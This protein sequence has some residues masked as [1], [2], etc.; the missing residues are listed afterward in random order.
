MRSL[1]LAGLLG[2]ISLPLSGQ[3]PPTPPAAGPL[4]PAR[5]P[6]FQETVLP[7]G[8]RLVLVEDHRQAVLSL[9]LSLPA[10]TAYDPSGNEGLS[11]MVAGLL[12]K[13]AGERSAEDLAATIEGVGGSL[14]AS[15]EEDFLAIQA[16]VLTPDAEL[17]FDLL[18]D[19][20]LR[21]TF[22][23]AEL[24]L[25]RTQTLSA[26]R[27]EL[28]QPA[29]VASRWLAR[30]LYGDRH[31]YG[32]SPTPAS[33]QAITRDDVTAFREA[34]F[35]PAGALLVL[36]GD[37][38]LP[39]AKHLAVKAF[40]EW[41]GRPAPVPPTGAP[42]TRLKTEILLVHRAGSVQSNILVGNTTFAPT[43]TS[44]YAATVA[45]K[46]LGGG[47]DSRLYLIL[48]EQK[49]WTYGAFSQLSRPRGI[50]TFEAS[51]EVRTEVT[52]SALRVMLWQLRRLGT[53]PVPAAE[54]EAAKSALVGSFPLTVQT[55]NQV[56]A[57]VTRAKLLGL[58]SDY[59]RTYR[60]RLAVMTASRLR[61]V[62]RSTIRPDAS[63]IVVVGDAS[64]LLDRL[65]AIAPVKII[66]PE[67][68]PL[69]PADLAGTQ[70]AVLDLDLGQLI[71]RRDSFTVLLG[72]KP[73][74]TQVST[75]EK[76]DSGYSY[77][78]DTRIGSVVQQNTEVGLDAAGSIVS[79]RQGGTMQGQQTRV[80]LHYG[81]G[82]VSGSA[83]VATQQ[84]PKAFTVDTALGSDV[85]DDN[86]LQ[87]LLPA[88]HWKEGAKWTLR[89][90]SAA[91][92]RFRDLTLAVTGAETI[93]V[94]AGTFE[95]YRAELSG[96]GQSVAFFL[97]KAAPHRIVKI[98]ISGTPL[99]FVAE[100]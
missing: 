57:A 95:T 76:T 13:G 16:D 88:V 58:P 71:P 3:F 53:D 38:T 100:P 48:S 31:P 90:F 51:A 17:A 39:E 21:P 40:G 79:L 37:I 94:P 96:D 36:A 15:S 50:G 4:V 45:N 70:P 56:A 46:V 44:Y 69:T 12:T 28:A 87:A 6:P 24:L 43:D 49:S 23:L 81:G 10:G 5:Y 91:E 97:G 72:G 22:N 66:D 19:I 30:G 85:V 61:T 11:D 9:R 33:V 26:L 41:T 2:L 64:A 92:N 83:T 47:A 18:S 73:A 35:R 29:S 27:A 84:G 42:P 63:L 7:N 52:D 1:R 25:L 89:V 98:T 60:T 62:A 54:L 82:R 65:Q 68:H 32:R 93:T 78:E 77:R 20:T 67:G 8:L 75:L 74:G 34:R 99:E 59:L 14:A 55:A 80:E 86:A